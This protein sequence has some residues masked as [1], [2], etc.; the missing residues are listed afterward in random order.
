MVVNKLIDK[1]VTKA[2]SD[3][4]S[5]QWRPTVAPLSFVEMCARKS[6]ILLA[7]VCHVYNRLNL[8]KVGAS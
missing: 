6:L 1:R 8:A 5:T 7:W 3:D 2:Y 4:I